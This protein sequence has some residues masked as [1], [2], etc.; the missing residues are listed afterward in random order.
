MPAPQ[1]AGRQTDGVSLPRFPANG[2][3]TAE[4]LTLPGDAFNPL[5][6][7]GWPQPRSREMPR[8]MHEHGG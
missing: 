8:R 6:A 7:F 1:S 3:S 5:G 2:L 4:R